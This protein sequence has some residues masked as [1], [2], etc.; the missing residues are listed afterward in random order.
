MNK[1]LSVLQ[2]LD[3]QAYKYQQQRMRQYWRASRLE[4]EEA[5]RNKTSQHG[6]SRGPLSMPHQHIHHSVSQL[7]FC[8]RVTG[9]AAAKGRLHC[10]WGNLYLGQD[11]MLQTTAWV[12]QLDLPYGPQP[13]RLCTGHG[14]RWGNFCL[15]CIC[16]T[17]SSSGSCFLNQTVPVDFKDL[18]EQ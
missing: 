13:G 17:D 5:E 4:K 14:G 2:A 7:L 1:D 11:F 10:C 15:I 3:T 18:V 6:C 12:I 9:E 16:S 8:S